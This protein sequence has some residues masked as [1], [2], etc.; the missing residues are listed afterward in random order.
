MDETVGQ[1]RL[2]EPATALRRPTPVAGA[3]GMWGGLTA[4]VWRAL[5]NPK[6]TE[7]LPTI[8]WIESYLSDDEGQDGC[9]TRSEGHLGVWSAVLDLLKYSFGWRSPAHGVAR[10]VESDLP[11]DD[12]RLALIH[13]LL[14]S[15]PRERAV[16][17]TAFLFNQKSGWGLTVYGHQGLVALSEDGSMTP[18]FEIPSW[19]HREYTTR[20]CGDQTEPPHVESPEYLPCQ[21]GGSD[22]LHL[23]GHCWAPIIRTATRQGA[24][25]R[26]FNHGT[27][28]RVLFHSD[29]DG[30]LGNATLIV[31]NYWGWYDT[32]NDLGATLKPLKSG[33]SWRVDVVCTPI[34]WLGTFRK[35]RM[36]GLWFTGPH[37]IH[38]WGEIA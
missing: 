20:G 13:H 35:S 23:S 28:G 9:L 26:G 21:P 1:L 29:S 11:T 10:W 36:T 30:G 14:G 25:V 19:V 3:D 24:P 37:S 7:V 22:N 17:L 4:S 6:G 34:A 32:L 5:A 18:D 27:E 15:Q 16:N 12:P 2:V 38:E 8:D 31:D 33:R